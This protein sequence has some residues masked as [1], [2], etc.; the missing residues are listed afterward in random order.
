MN[1]NESAD[2]RS[3]QS[4]AHIILIVVAALAA[5]ATIGVVTLA[6]CLFFNKEVNV[7][8]LTAFVGIVNFALGAIAGVLAKTYATPA[9]P[10]P[11]KV[12]MTNTPENPASVREV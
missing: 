2:S 10:E 8:L 3:Q 6:L 12:E 9:N 4:N 7:A 5:N 1:A 11:A